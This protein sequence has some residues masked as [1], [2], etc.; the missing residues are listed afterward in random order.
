[1]DPL[2]IVGLAS[3]IIDFINFTS[4]FVKAVKE[5]RNS[6]NTGENT[7]LLNVTEKVQKIGE[8]IEDGLKKISEDGVQL[9]R[10]DEVRDSHTPIN[11]DAIPS[12]RV[13]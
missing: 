1:M 11:G 3:N 8:D 13:C 9:S 4:K 2:T 12:K 7:V 10:K 5:L 6:S